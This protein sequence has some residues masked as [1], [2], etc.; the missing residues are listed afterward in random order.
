MAQVDL[1]PPPPP[2]PPCR[3]GWSQDII[4]ETVKG[5]RSVEYAQFKQIY[6]AAKGIGSSTDGL[7]E[8]F[9]LFQKG[10]VSRCRWARVASGR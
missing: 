7:K 10:A 2:A 4:S 6:E 1:A 3:R 8:S 5:A 9:E